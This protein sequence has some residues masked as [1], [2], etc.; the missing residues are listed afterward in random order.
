MLGMCNC[1]HIR[2]VMNITPMTMDNMN[3]VEFIMWGIKFQ[4]SGSKCVS[5]I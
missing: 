1:L 3:S 5:N 4:V 2:G